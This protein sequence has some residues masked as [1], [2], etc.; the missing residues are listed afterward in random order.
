MTEKV[1]EV[2]AIP[3]YLQTL[4]SASTVRVKEANRVVTITPI[5][6]SQVETK[7]SCPFL[8]IAT[9]SELTVEKFLQ[10]KREERAAEYE[11]DL[12]T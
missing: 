8:G 12:R 10:W 9:D 1:M 3:S 6:E 2:N 5:N 11:K 4:L 7:Y